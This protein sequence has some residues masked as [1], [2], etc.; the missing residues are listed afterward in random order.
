[1]LDWSNFCIKINVFLMQ[2]YV[3]AEA[4]LDIISINA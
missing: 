3:N 4:T 1:M 2:F